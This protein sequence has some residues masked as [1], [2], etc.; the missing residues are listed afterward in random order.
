MTLLHIE[1]INLNRLRF[2]TERGYTIMKNFDD[3]LTMI[4]KEPSPA[5]SNQQAIDSIINFTVDHP[6]KAIA[7]VAI[8]ALMMIG[9]AVGV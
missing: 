1:A 3:T 2:Y 5:S 7:I 8:I 4:P 9:V 6:T